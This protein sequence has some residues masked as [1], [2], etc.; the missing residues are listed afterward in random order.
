MAGMVACA[1]MAVCFASSSVA[2]SVTTQSAAEAYQLVLNQAGATKPVRDSVT[3]YVAKTVRDGRGFIPG[4]ADDW[5]NH[6][7]AKY[8]RAKSPADKNHNGIPDDWETAHKLNRAI[9]SATGRDLDTRYDNI[10]VYL[11]SL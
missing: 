11:N 10:E 5:P 6:G 4:T 1:A 9:S 2:E 3:T 8:R 7:Y